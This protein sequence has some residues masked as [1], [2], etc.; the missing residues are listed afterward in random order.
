MNAKTISCTTLLFSMLFVSGCIKDDISG[1]KEPGSLAGKVKSI[2]ARI[3]TTAGELDWWS[4]ENFSFDDKGRPATYVYR[5]YDNGDIIDSVQFT[6]LQDKA[7]KASFDEYG[8][9]TEDQMFFNARGLVDST[10]S[11]DEESYAY[12]YNSKGLKTQERSYRSN[13]LFWTTDISYDANDNPVHYK[14]VPADVNSSISPSYTRC[15]FYDIVTNPLLVEANN[16]FNDDFLDTRHLTKKKSFDTDPSF[17]S[18]H[19]VYSYTYTFDSQNRVAT[20]K[21]LD[22]HWPDQYIIYTYTYY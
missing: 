21:E 1:D 20:I 4:T 19:E 15:E 14:N 16:S 9:K 3:Y 8:N 6:Y 10:F 11:S 5:E 12:T 13:E 2:K 18:I 17:S 22:T 7:I